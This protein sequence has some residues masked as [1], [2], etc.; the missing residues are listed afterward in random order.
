[1]KVTYATLSKKGSRSNNEDAV[2]VI[3]H[4]EADRWLGIVCD[5]MGGH[6]CGE[7]ASEVVVEAITEYWEAH[8]E[9]PDSYEKVKTAC[10]KASIAFD[11]RATDMRHT[12]MGSTMVMACIQGDTVTIVHL[13]DSRCYLQRKDNELLYQT[14][15]HLRYEF[16]WELVDKCFFSYRPEKA[17]PEVRQFKLQSGDRILLC[18][19]GLYKSM[20]PDILKERMMDDKTPEQILDVYDFLCEKSGDDNYTAILATIMEI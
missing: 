15:D 6:A 16:G 14:K 11:K 7:V 2:K 4:S 18:S 10:R 8:L 1:M 13:G 20:Y 12:E 17:D 3:D 5:G 9:E 19:D